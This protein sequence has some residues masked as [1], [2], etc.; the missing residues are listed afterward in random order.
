MLRFTRALRSVKLTTGITGLDVIPNAREVLIRLY[1][2]TL[3]D[4]AVMAP[5]VPY[6]QVVEKTARHRMEI[7]KKHTNVGG[8]V[9]LTPSRSLSKTF[10]ASLCRLPRSRQPLAVVRLK[11]SLNRPRANSSL[12]RSTPA[13]V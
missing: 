13:G 2:K 1:E 10:R 6:R 12:S 3:V 5:E 9:G 8:V 7:V 11:S 4:V